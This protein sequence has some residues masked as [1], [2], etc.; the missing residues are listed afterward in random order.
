MNSPMMDPVRPAGDVP[1]AAAVPASTQKQDE[2][3]AIAEA[4]KRRRR[5]EQQKKRLPLTEGDLP[6]EDEQP[7]GLLGEDDEVPPTVDCL[8]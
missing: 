8:A 5:R 6:A 1:Q 2:R 7:A 3:R 4:R